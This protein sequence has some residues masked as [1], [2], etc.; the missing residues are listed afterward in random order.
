MATS[1]TARTAPTAPTAST[2]SKDWTVEAADRIESVVTAVRDKTVAPLTTAARGLV[3]G[4][5]AGVLAIVLL[6]VLVIGT[7]RAGDVYLFDR[8]SQTGGPHVWAVDLI[9]GGILV[10]AGLLLW[11]RR[12]PR[13]RRD[14]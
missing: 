3:Y 8:H 13:S 11:S 5:L 6:V 14:R 7:V 4:L 10:L 9:V 12:K 2:G 1:A